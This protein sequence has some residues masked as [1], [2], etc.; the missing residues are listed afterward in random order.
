[1]ENNW[2]KKQLNDKPIYHL[3]DNWDKYS[4]FKAADLTQADNPKDQAKIPKDQAD[5][6]KD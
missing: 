5:I 6:V 3:K 4:T 1:M 2:S